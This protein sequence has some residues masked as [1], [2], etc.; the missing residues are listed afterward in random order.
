MKRISSFNRLTEYL[1]MS[2][3][4][5]VL[6]LNISSG[7]LIIEPQ[8]L[9]INKTFGVNKLIQVNITNPDSFSYKN[10]Q[11]TNPYSDMSKIDNL[12]P[13]SYITTNINV[14]TDTDINT[15]LRIKGFY[16]S[17]IGLS[18]DTYEVE[19]DIDGISNCNSLSMIKGDS[20]EFINNEINFPITVTKNGE[21]SPFLIVPKNSS[22]IQNFPVSGENTWIFKLSDVF[23]IDTCTFQVKDDTGLVNDF[24]LDGLMNLNVNVIHSPTNIT[25]TTLENSYDMEFFEQETDVIKIINTGNNI[26]SDVQLSGD[27]LSFDKNNFDIPV[28]DSV[29]VEYTITPIITKTEQTNKT[30][31]KTL[32]ISGNFPTKTT[33]LNIFIQKAVIEDGVLNSNTSDLI[34][35]IEQYCEQNPEVC[36]VKPKIVYRYVGNGT[37]N[38][39]E[40]DFD[41]VLKFMADLSNDIITSDNFEKQSIDSINSRTDKIEESIVNITNYLNNL[42]KDRQLTNNFILIGF[43]TLLG[44]LVMGITGTI[45]WYYWRKNKKEE[46][47]VFGI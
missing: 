2:L 18:N 30:Y 23:E 26:A 10:I 27:W 8:N 4:L 38:N 11:L 16:E 47:G 42:E 3:I 6:S 17:V 28:G 25:I 20:I 24:N 45:I 1:L 5:I 36:G 35:I 12:N 29:N 15:Q 22:V 14:T 9:T 21:S 19:M 34:S 40:T 44:F 7:S 41:E 32:T 37:G 39:S 43:I 31:N 46:E 33:T 13:N